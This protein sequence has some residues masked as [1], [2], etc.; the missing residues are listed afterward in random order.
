MILPVLS[1]TDLQADVNFTNK[2]LTYTVTILMYYLL[3]CPVKA[4]GITNWRKN[5][6]PC[7]NT[8][9]QVINTTVPSF[10]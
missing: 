7:G 1:S 6:L 5:Y 10:L 9:V 4:K 3:P 8:S 2:K